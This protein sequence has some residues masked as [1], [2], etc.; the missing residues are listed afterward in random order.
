MKEVGMAMEKAVRLNQG[1]VVCI[2]SA[3]LFGKEDF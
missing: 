1:W 2:G 3:R